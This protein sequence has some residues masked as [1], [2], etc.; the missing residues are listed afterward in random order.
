[1]RKAAVFAALA[2][3]LAAT[4]AFAADKS[5]LSDEDQIA[6]ALNDGCKAVVAKDIDGMIAPFKKTDTLT[7]FDFGP[8][9]SRGW[10]QLRAANEEFVK[11][12]ATD[13][14]CIYRE[15][16]PVILSTDAAYSWAI[17][18]AGG[19]MKDGTKMDITIRST[20]IWRKIDGAW[21]I[22][23]EHNSFPT[24]MKTGMADMQSRP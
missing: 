7:M 24:D 13:T 16:H 23:H 15:I 1:M 14:Y 4:P 5:A 18:S 21:R 20:D 19:T 3:M 12:A 2:A 17:M 9:R 8:P 11:E 22:V 10:A 6:K